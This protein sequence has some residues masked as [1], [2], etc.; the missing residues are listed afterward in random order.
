MF[1]IL[2]MVVVTGT[3]TYVNIHR[4]GYLLSPSPAPR[5]FYY[6]IIQNKT[7]P[8]IP[9]AESFTLLPLLK[10]KNFTLPCFYLIL[11]LKLFIHL[12]IHSFSS[13]LWKLCLDEMLCLVLGSQDAWEGYGSCF[14]GIHN[15]GWETDHKKLII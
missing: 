3:C 11:S 2:I 1:Y 5:E 12:L 8:Q 14:Q 15:W 7:K 13:L 4:N 9:L 6:M 10:C